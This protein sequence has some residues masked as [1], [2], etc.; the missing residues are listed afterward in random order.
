MFP[1]GPRRMTT[2]RGVALSVLCA[3]CGA[4]NGAKSGEV[5]KDWTAQC[6]S[7]LKGT[8]ET[9][10]IFQ[11]L[12]LKKD[13][14]QL[15]HLAVG[16]LAKSGQAAAFLTLPL[17]VSLP[18]GVSLSV[19]NGPPKRF[20]FERCEQNGCLAPLVLDDEL[21]RS[22]KAG[23]QARVA[24]FDGARR[25]ISVPVSLLGFTAGFNTLSKN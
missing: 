8:A 25:E 7:A 3:A 24:F 10:Y 22:L 15:L 18:G 1:I 16:Y 20:R 2:L 14:Q 17:G 9:C 4:A 23:R 5:F 6:E 11:N 21:I 13:E 19:D 12:R